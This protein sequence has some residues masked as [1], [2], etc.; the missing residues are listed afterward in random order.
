MRHRRRGVGVLIRRWGEDFT[1]TL[2]SMRSVAFVRDAR[3]KVNGFV[4]NIDERS[5]DIRFAKVR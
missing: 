4:V 2:P 5:R 1:G 3:G